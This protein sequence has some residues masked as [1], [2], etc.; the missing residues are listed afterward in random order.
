[1]DIDKLISVLVAFLNNNH[2]SFYTS[3]KLR[4]NPNVCHAAC[5]WFLNNVARL[6]I[7]DALAYLD[8][9]D[10]AAFQQAQ[11]AALA[12]GSMPKQVLQQARSSG[13]AISDKDIEAPEY[14]LASHSQPTKYLTSITTVV[15]NFVIRFLTGTNDGA[16][17]YM[18]A[19]GSGGHV[20]CVR[21]HV[22]GLLIYDPNM[23]VMS[24]RL[25]DSDTWAEVLRRILGWYKD[26]MGLTRFA[27]LPE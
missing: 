27:Y 23:G 2:G 5:L 8:Q 12:S 20:I 17:I 25:A 22:A 15:A 18:A 11:Q 1:V 10:K 7:G 3:T 9:T 6:G 4:D 16:M 21:R 13:K 19:E 26:N 24:C 14:V